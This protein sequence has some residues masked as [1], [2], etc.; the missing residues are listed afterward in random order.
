MKLQ[1][2]EI[3]R[4]VEGKGEESSM[5]L[6]QACFA[7]QSPLCCTA[8]TTQIGVTHSLKQCLGARVAAIPGQVSVLDSLSPSLTDT[9]T[10]R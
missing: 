1:E 3:A 9:L 6:F 7:A 2:H 8:A 10:G 4:E 5:T